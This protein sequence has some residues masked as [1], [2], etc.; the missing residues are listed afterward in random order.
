MFKETQA[1]DQVFGAFSQGAEDMIHVF[2]YG[3]WAF[4]LLALIC[5]LA[6]KGRMWS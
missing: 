2:K 1:L 6:R 4:L 3:L 5:Y